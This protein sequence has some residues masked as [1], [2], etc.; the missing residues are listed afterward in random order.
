MA[1][2]KKPGTN[3]QFDEE[4]G[5]GRS[6]VDRDEQGRII[7]DEDPDPDRVADEDRNADET[8]KSQRP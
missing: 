8:K 3:E 1:D 7:S 6:N 4:T 2:P 5:K